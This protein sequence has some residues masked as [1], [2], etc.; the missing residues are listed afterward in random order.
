MP[1]KTRQSPPPL[2]ERTRLSVGAAR[3]TRPFDLARE[4][5]VAVVTGVFMALA[6]AFGTDQAPIGVRLV[7][8]VG[9]MATGTL[10]A[11]GVTMA[12][13]RVEL[14]ETR[15]WLWAA[16]LTLAITP[17][18]SVIVW[19]VS[20]LTFHHDLR[21][22][23]I[24]GYAAPVVLVTAGVTVITVLVQRTPY[25][26]HAETG[27]DPAPAPFLERLPLK[28][29]GAELYAVQAEDHYLRLHT[30]KGQDLIL[31]RLADAL[32]EL[33]GL[34]GAQVHRSWW[35]S[36]EAVVEASRGN[37]RATLILRNGATAP[38]SRRY[39]GVLREAGWI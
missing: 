32:A 22:I 2:R 14:F 29:R 13:L 21:P 35:V 30:S 31:M 36:R 28:L 16:L 6:G 37:G 9:L 3:L 27:P 18:L 20:G 8:W 12:A 23:D 17:P 7:Y 5:A 15:P 34:E 10:L 19:L 1:P 38:V 33:Q 26:T 11:R 4:I 24:L 25:M 39:A